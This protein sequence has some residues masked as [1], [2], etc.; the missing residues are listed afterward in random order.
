MA[1]MFRVWAL[2]GSLLG[3]EL[4]PKSFIGYETMHAGQTDEPDHVVPNGLR[5]LI[6]EEGE[7]VRNN[8]YS[9]NAIR[10]GTVTDIEPADRKKIVEAITAEKDPQSAEEIAKIAG[11]PVSVIHKIV[12]LEALFAKRAEAAKAAARGAAENAAPAKAE[13]GPKP[14]EGSEV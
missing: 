10:K 4:Y 2:P 11:V 14:S 9:R 8:T 1:E 12:E 7:L 6:R 3:H 5:Y 13:S